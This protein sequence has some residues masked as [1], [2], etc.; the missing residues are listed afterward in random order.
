MR[1]F[2]LDV[3]IMPPLFFKIENPKLS[4]VNDVD[5]K[6]KWLDMSPTLEETLPQ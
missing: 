4:E 2:F 5:G 1:C 6:D 3:L